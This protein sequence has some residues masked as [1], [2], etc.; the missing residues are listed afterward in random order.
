[1]PFGY[2]ARSPDRGSV[3]REIQ[4]QTERDLRELMN[5]QE[6]RA[7][8]VKIGLEP[9]VLSSAESNEFLKGEL[10]RWGKIVRD[11]KIKID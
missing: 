8:I 3:V 10:V 4:R 6:L 9:A 5:G 2:C 11:K 7:Q 1:M